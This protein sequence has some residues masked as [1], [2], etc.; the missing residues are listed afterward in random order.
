[1]MEPRQLNMKARLLPAPKL[2]YGQKRNMSP[3]DGKWNLRGLQFLRPSPIKS[4]ALVYLPYQRPIEESALKRFGAEMVTIFRNCGMSVPTEGPVILVANPEGHMPTIVENACAAA[5]GKFGA[6][7]DV[8][9]FVLQS[10]S[11]QIY[12]VLKMGLDVKTGI[13]SQVMLQDK[14]IT[15]R[16]AAQYLANIA[17]K[18][19]VKLGG[20]NCVLHEPVFS[21]GRFMLVGGDI[22]HASPGAL[23]SATPPPS[24]AALVGTW[25]RECTA[26]TAVTA[27]QESTLATIANIKPMFAQLLARYIEQNAGS[28]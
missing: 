2:V 24:C 12:Q 7:P 16:G 18:V 10:S 23:R 5:S 20:T 4:W 27:M 9:Y 22:S 17:M 6:R 15:S 1:M 25:D 11:A 26:Y 3:R 28:K 21:S 8:L 19:N 14:A 13:A